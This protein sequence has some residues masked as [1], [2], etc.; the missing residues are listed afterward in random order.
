MELEWTKEGQMSAH[1]YLSN[2]AEGAELLQA[3]IEA[4]GGRFEALSA[5]VQEEAIVVVLDHKA[6]NA[7]HR[8]A[9]RLRNTAGGKRAYGFL[10]HLYDHFERG[11]AWSDE[12]RG[13]LKMCLSK[14]NKWLEDVA[15]NLEQHWKQYQ[16]SM[17]MLKS[18]GYEHIDGN[19]FLA[20][21]VMTLEVATNG[22]IRIH[23][24]DYRSVE[25]I[26]AAIRP[27]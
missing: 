6:A 12:F 25:D 14:V 21:D 11:Q 1:V 23:N 3:F 7:K 13:T 20:A 2:R 15:H 19:R 5:V 22:L 27:R 24:P 10:L 4:T 8:L 9:I 17:S 16:R 18:A 26:I